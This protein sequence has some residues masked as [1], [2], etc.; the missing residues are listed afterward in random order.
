MA[1]G[2]AANDLSA[3]DNDD[4]DQEEETEVVENYRNAIPWNMNIQSTSGY[5]NAARENNFTNASLMFS[6][7]GLTPEWKL[8]FPQVMTLLIKVL[9]SRN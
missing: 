7:N 2:G 6:G 9:I 3:L 5:T 1:S 8:D 4:L